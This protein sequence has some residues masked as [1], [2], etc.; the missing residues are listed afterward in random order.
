MDAASRRDKFTNS[1]RGEAVGND[2]H[3]GGGGVFSSQATRERNSSGFRDVSLGEAAAGI[4]T[5]WAADGNCEQQTS[6][7]SRS[8]YEDKSN[9][10]RSGS[11]Q[12]TGC[13]RQSSR[14][15]GRSVCKFQGQVRQ[16]YLEICT[17]RI[18]CTLRPWKQIFEHWTSSPWYLELSWRQA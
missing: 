14:I 12:E 15:S 17:R 4:R 1:S 16:M 8:I 10:R 7:K 6:G 5:G 18:K 2:Q 3:D 13:H 11:V 9:P